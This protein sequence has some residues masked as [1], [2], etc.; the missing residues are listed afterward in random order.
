VLIVGN[1]LYNACCVESKQYVAA[2][3]NES[4]QSIA[5]GFVVLAAMNLSNL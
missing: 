1:V 4:K 3:C 2:G 5:V